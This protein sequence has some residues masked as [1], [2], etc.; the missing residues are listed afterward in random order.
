MLLLQNPAWG[1]NHNSM[2]SII[3]TQDS[4]CSGK[5]CRRLTGRPDLMPSAEAGALAEPSQAP[6]VGVRSLKLKLSEAAGF[7]E[8]DR[9]SACWARE[10]SRE[11]F[12]RLANFWRP[13]SL[14]C[15]WCCCWCSCTAKAANICRA[16]MSGRELEREGKRSK[17][18]DVRRSSF[19]F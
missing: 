10:L 11:K 3:S 1:F 19:L 5:G 9:R 15:C 12:A 16:Q 7:S 17:R 2:K 14:P 13:R 18:R 8:W 4:P 6:R